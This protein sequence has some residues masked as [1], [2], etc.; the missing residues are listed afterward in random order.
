MN[1]I[2]SHI[3]QSAV[4]ALLVALAILVVYTWAQGFRRTD[5][6]RIQLANVAEG[7]HE[8]GALRRLADAAV[9]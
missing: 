8:R 5:R 1:T 9:A 4:L 3:T 7:T 6:G 2:I